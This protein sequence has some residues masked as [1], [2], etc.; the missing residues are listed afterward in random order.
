[1]KTDDLSERAYGGGREIT[2]DE[3]IQECRRRDWEIEG[4][5]EA[6]ESLVWRLYPFIDKMKRK[7]GID[8]RLCCW[9][10]ENR[11]DG[12]DY[13]TYWYHP[14]ITMRQLRR[15]HEPDEEEIIRHIKINGLEILEVYT[16]RF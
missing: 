3:W 10:E 2:R 14:G 1:M 12:G 7:T 13:R 8:H 11:W 15:L 6:N 5:K 4:L 16:P 9:E